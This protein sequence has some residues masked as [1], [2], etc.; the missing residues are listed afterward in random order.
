MCDNA[1]QM[2]DAASASQLTVKVERT[3]DTVV[4]RCGGRLIAGIND[5]LYK[6]VS[7][8]IPGA[9]RMVLDLT[10]LTH[11]DSM[12][13]G[14]VVRLYVSTKAAGCQLEL[15]NIG[16]RIRKLLD[17]TRLLSVFTVCGENDIRII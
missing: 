6:Q 7:P 14:T 5:S 1:L 2:P 12:G 10:N 13:L 15:V 4:V 16:P 17:V 11:M 9:K 8:L 3:G